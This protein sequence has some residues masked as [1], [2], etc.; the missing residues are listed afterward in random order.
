MSS[1][2]LPAA[3]S[4]L[5]SQATNLH[6]TSEANVKLTGTQRIITLA[7][8]TGDRLIIEPILDQIHPRLVAHNLRQYVQSHERAHLCGIPPLPLHTDSVSILL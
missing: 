3:A 5:T 1:Q 2:A 8:Q 7:A 6:V 4:H